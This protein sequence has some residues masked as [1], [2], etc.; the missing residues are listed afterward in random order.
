MHHLASFSCS[1]PMDHIF[2]YIYYIPLL[3]ESQ[4]II[5]NK[6]PTINIAQPIG[7]RNGCFMVVV[8]EV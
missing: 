8:F 6:M 4:A 1:V 3:V 5:E 2:G 7:I